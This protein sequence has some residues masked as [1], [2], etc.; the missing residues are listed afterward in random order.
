MYDIIIIG[1]G[2]AGMT[3]ALYARR[4]GKTVLIIEKDGFGG[5]I[6]HS[7]RIEN[8][9]ASMSISGS[10]FADKLLEQVMEQGA[11]VELETVIAAH[12][13]GRIK[14]VI[15]EEGGNYEA[16]SLIIASGVRHRML[17]ISGEEELVGHGISFCA[18]CDGDFFSGQTVA[19]VGGGN[20]ALQEATLLADTC[21]ELI[22]IQNLDHF[23]GE[24]SLLTPLLRRS[25]VRAMM[26]TVI[27]D[28]IKKDSELAGLVLETVSDGKTHEV[29]CQGLFV[30]VG[31]IPENRIF[32]QLISLDAHGY[33]DSGED[34]TTKTSGIF[35]AGD[36]RSK[37][38]RQLT[39][40]C[41]DGSV[42]ALSACR[43]IDS[44]K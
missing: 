1:G 3:A 20:S 8:Y 43:Y 25:N 22:L 21:Q 24:E 41:A 13:E 36:C 39:T 6:S 30:A 23:T 26:G 11:D 29:S 16:L 44:I 12:D 35:V 38:V 4:N 19:V 2:P 32:E 15:T 14:R 27:K 33:A 28:F 17:G 5:Q 10:E 18:V 9:P 31:L 34:C 37:N 7:P 40:A 42:A